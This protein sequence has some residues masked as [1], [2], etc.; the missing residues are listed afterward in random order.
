M[1]QL[2]CTARKKRSEDQCGSF[3]M[4]NGKCAVHGGK[5][6]RGADQPMF[7]HGRYSKYLPTR[8]LGQYQAA[9]NDPDLL[10]MRDEVALIDARLVDVL[11]RIQTGESPA[12]WLLLGSV[13]TLLQ[14]A[15][16]SAEDADDVGE[17]LERVGDLSGQID[18]LVRRALSEESAWEHARSLVN[19]RMK[20]VES[21]RKRMVDLQQMMT[22]EQALLLAGAL[23]DTVRRHVAD[24]RVLAA[25]S[26]DVDRIL[27]KSDQGRVLTGDVLSRT[28]T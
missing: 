20:L 22:S 2:R 3:A 17:A 23:V 4:A 9:R 12:A 15:V 7:S 18:A 16:R 1:A 10:A 19:Q 25:I 6:L 13:V 26:A 28:S 8:L 14:E 27:S 24:R 11:A 5:S 21:E